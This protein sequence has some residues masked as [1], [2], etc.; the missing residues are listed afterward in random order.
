MK[1]LVP[2]RLRE[3]VDLNFLTLLLVH[4]VPQQSQK[5]FSVWSIQKNNHF[6]RQFELL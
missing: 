1:F 6:V 3:K 5:N 4:I 2:N